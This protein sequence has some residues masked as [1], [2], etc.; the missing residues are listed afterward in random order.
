MIVLDACALVEM[1]RGSNVGQTLRG[2]AGMDDKAVSCDLIR[3]E[4]A[5]VFRK[6][7]RT[8]ITASEAQ[9]LFAESLMLIDEFY[10]LEDLQDEALRESI[11]L[12]HSTYDM[13]YFVLARR[14]GAT[15]FTTDRRLMELCAEN[16]VDCIQE[17]DFEKVQGE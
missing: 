5:N 10:P 15:L 13:F 17:A 9:M 3:A 14:T 8:G 16:G 11:R 7:M 12:S 4:T 6:L 1:G 2:L